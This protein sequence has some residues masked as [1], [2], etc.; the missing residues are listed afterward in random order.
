MKQEFSL[1]RK[2]LLFRG[3]T[4][5]ANFGRMRC[6]DDFRGKKLKGRKVK[7]SNL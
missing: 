5:T 6:N 3:Y 7:F 1:S 4:A 2:F